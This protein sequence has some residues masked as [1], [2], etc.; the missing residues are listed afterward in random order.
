MRSKT[1]L[2]APFGNIEMGIP[3]VR[4]S[5]DHERPACLAGFESLVRGDPI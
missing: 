2:N 5:Q 4:G 3:Y 1:V